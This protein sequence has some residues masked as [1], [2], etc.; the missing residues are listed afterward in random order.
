MAKKDEP[1]KVLGIIDAL[2]SNDKE[3][4]FNNSD[5]GIAYKTG[6]P[7]LDYYLGYRK[8]IYDENDNIIES[9]PILGV[10]SGSILT[11]IGK[12]STG[13][14][15]IADQIAGNI[16]RPFKN[17]FIL[18][19]DLEQ[20]S[21][22]S[23]IHNLTRLSMSDIAAGKYLLRKDKYTI[24]DINATI[25]RIYNEK[26]SNPDKYL[27]NTHQLDEFG[28]EIII[29]EPTVIIIDSIASLSS[30]IDDKINIAKLEEVGS[31]ADTLR[32]TGE[33]GRFFKG[34][35]P[36]LNASNIILITINHIKDKPQLGF[37]PEP[38]E[39]LYLG[40][41]EHLPGGR[42]P[43]FYASVLLKFIAIGSEKYNF[44][45]DG[46]DGYGLKT[47]IIKS[48][49]NQAGRFVNLVYDKNK[50]VDALRSTIMYAK[51]LGLTG[52]NKNKFYF[53]DNK[54]EA[55]SLKN[56][57]DEF[58]ERKELY[59]IMFDSVTPHLTRKLSMLS[60][61]DLEVSEEEMMY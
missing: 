15:T 60:K 35:M 10:P 52:G 32:A 46:F 40:Q 1:K 58:R 16:V 13:K 29:F 9:Y 12:P 47:M 20:S 37:I 7:Q 54:D 21:N 6:F 27:Y 18:K 22:M 23:R 31:Q 2:R 59:K 48:R 8:N 45:D 19:F 5:S 57:H 4:Y 42:A 39:I 17:G 14:T 25:L 41:N 24:N 61:E 44:E 38:S 53:N 30:G 34:I 28:K 26:I 36:Y 50:G 33:I 56:V 51:E 43:Q 55:F 49:G 3:G 11:F